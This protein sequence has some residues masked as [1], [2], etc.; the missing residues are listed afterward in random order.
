MT[1][2]VGQRRG[3]A[4]SGCRC[5][6][7]H[8]AARS[9]RPRQRGRAGRAA[10]QRSGPAPAPTSVRSPRRSGRTSQPVPTRPHRAMP[11]RT[12]QP[13]AATSPRRRPIPMRPRRRRI[14]HDDREDTDDDDRQ[15][16]DGEPDP[17]GRER[18]KDVDQAGRGLVHDGR[19][20][21]ALGRDLHGHDRDAGTRRQR[22]IGR[23]VLDRGQLGRELLDLAAHRWSAGPGPRGRR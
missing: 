23:L 10:R 22:R 4:G 1:R 19:W 9:R 20:L 21:P 12:G 15:P 17:C 14:A 7:R 3:P 11:A 8:R 2:T 16:H 6:H 18:L 5:R 13:G